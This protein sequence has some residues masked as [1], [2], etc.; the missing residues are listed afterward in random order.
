MKMKYGTLLLITV[1]VIAG[2]IVALRW[3]SPRQTTPGGSAGNGTKDSQRPLVFYCAAGV[4]KPV[5]EVAHEY[6]QTY[7][8][9]IQIEPG[10][11]G[12]LLS[13]L[14]TTRGRGH[15]YLAADDSY[16]QRAR[17]EFDLVAESIPVARL[18]PVIAVKKGN[19]KKIH[20]IAR[21]ASGKRWVKTIK[22]GHPSAVLRHHCGR[23]P[24]PRTARHAFS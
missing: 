12:K 2:L 17:D 14:R 23:M 5:E 22:T 13:T 3:G 10:G 1:V 24:Q 16:I 15:L 11:S 6:E 20:S 8:V 9:P 4:M 18:Y 21:I 7:G 19:P